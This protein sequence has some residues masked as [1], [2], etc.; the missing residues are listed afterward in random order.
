MAPLLVWT[1]APGLV[2]DLQWGHHQLLPDTREA[3]KAW[4]EANVPAGSSIL[5]DQ[6]HASPN[7][8]MDR[9]RVEEMLKQNLALGSK[10]TR[11]YELLLKFHPGGGYRIW[12]IQRSAADLWSPPAIVERSRK[13]G[14]YLDVTPGLSVLREKG[15]RY[16]VTS[17]L[18]ADPSRAPELKTFFEE[19]SRQGRVLMEFRADNRGTAGPLLKV[20]FIGG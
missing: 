15:I 16:V 8:V 20:Y 4:I 18:G 14:P 19:L 11:Y 2:S 7:L 9:S 5:L 10:R 6:L 13:E 1:L 3:A 12:R 17:E